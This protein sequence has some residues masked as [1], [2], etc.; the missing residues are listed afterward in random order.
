MDFNKIEHF[1]MNKKP[2]KQNFF[3]R[4]LFNILTF[5]LTCGHPFK[6][7]KDKRLKDLKEPH[8]ILLNHTSMADLKFMVRM[9]KRQKFNYVIALD[10]FLDASFTHLQE[11]IMRNYGAIAKRKFTNDRYL[12][13][14]MKYA[15]TKNKHN[16][17]MYPEARFCLS[18]TFSSTPESLGKVIKVLGVPVVTNQTLGTYISQ[19]CWSDKVDRNAPIEANIKY[20]LTKEE[21]EELSYE[22]IN[23]RI[24]EALDYNDFDYQLDRGIK[25]KYKKRAEGI[26]HILYQCPHCLKE[27]KMYSHRTKFWCGECK[28][29]WEFLENGRL[30]ATNGET[31]FDNIPDWFEWERENVRQEILRGEYNFDDDVMIY[32]LPNVKKLLP[33]GVGHLTHSV[34]KGFHLTGHFGDYHIDVEREPLSMYSCH[35]EYNFWK[36]GEC[37]DISTLDDTFFVHALNHRDILTKFHFAT[38]EIYKIQQLKLQEEKNKGSN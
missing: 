7:N 15:L 17:V 3:I 32:S 27:H 28:H 22:E 21:V 37:L 20:L 36:H 6:I 2:M 23:Q 8:L 4:S 13:K 11:F 9:N 33:V 19:P 14:Q 18:G 10:A 24:I 30:K 12:V 38:E 34:E 26:N 1:D 35:V 5:L 25:I 29:E 31:Y 16:V